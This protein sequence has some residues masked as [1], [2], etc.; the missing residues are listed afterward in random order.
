MKPIQIIHPISGPNMLDNIDNI[1]S[2]AE[3]LTKEGYMVISPMHAYIYLDD[4]VPEE[5]EYA[6]QCCEKL[7]E[8]VHNAGGEAWVYGDWQNSEG[9]KRELEKCRELVMK[10]VFKE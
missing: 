8:M 4:D 3:K 9:C 1:S 6:L 2:I 10:V 7:L 5:R